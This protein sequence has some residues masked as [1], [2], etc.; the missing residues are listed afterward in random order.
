MKNFNDIN[1]DYLYLSLYD[2]RKELVAEM[3][4][5]FYE[6][7]FYKKGEYPV[8][9]PDNDLWHG[10]FFDEVGDRYRHISHFKCGLYRKRGLVSR[11]GQIPVK[12]TF[13]DGKDFICSAVAIPCFFN[14]KYLLNNVKDII[15]LETGECIYIGYERTYK[16]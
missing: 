8:Y 15:N 13:R 9:G 1:N 16:L 11:Y 10:Y 14:W 5:W 3:Q 6:L 2:Y 4:K 12:L 7:V